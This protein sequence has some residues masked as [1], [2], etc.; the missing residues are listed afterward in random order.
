MLDALFIDFEMSNAFG[1]QL[2]RI[3]HSIGL[4]LSVDF[5]PHP[6]Y[7][8]HT[9]DKVVSSVRGGILSCH[10]NYCKVFI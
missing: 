4:Y 7:L 6:K 1:T 8:Q 10:S 2:K 3:Q 9:G 5:S